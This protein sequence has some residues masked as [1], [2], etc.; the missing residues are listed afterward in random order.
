MPSGPCA[1]RKWIPGSANSR[2]S[3][4]SGRHPM[5]APELVLAH[6]GDQT[7]SAQRQRDV[8]LF[9]DDFQGFGNPFLAERTQAV[10]KWPADIGALG[11]EAERFQHVLAGAD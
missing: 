7:L 8:H 6:V 2:C 10:E 5:L 3:P 4:W 11:A 9:A 1:S